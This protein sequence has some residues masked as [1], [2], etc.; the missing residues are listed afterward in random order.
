[1]TAAPLAPADP[2]LAD[3]PPGWAA[4]GHLRLPTP[5]ATDALAAR[6]AALL[7][8]G[9]TLL[10]QGRLGAGKSH[11]ARAAI[12]ALIGPGGDRVDIPSPTFTLVQVYDTAPGE[13]WHADLYRLTHPQEAEELGL[14]AAMEAAICLV[15]WPD[16]LAPDWP[17]GAVCLRLAADPGAP[18]A[19]SLTLIA[20]EASALAAR[21]LPALGAA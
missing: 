9:D 12:R 5:A 3:P 14:D 6:L 16:R 11:L 1:M 18:E 20:P 10:L 19:R 8:P 17:A 13:V 4:R 7:A 21:L 15:E 2:D